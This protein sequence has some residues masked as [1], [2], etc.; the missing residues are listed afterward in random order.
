MLSYEDALSYALS[1]DAVFILGS[2]F[3]VGASSKVDKSLFTGRKLSQELAKEL[4]IKEELELDIIAQEYIDEK[5][6]F[7]LT[8]YLKQH[9]IVDSYLEYYNAFS[10]IKHARIYSTNY[11]NLV[12]RIFSDDRQ[13]INSHTL[14]TEMRKANKNKFILHIT[15]YINNLDNYF[16]DSFR[17]TYRSYDKLLYTPWVKLL[18][19]DIRASNAVFII[20]LSFKSDLDLRRII[21]NDDEIKG[22]CFIIDR[23]DIGDY[24]FKLLSSYG[25]V[26]KNGVSHFCEELSKATPIKYEQNIDRY[27]F[28]SFCKINKTKT[29]ETPTDS[30]VFD[31]FFLG[32]THTHLFHKDL[33]DQFTTLVN[34][35]KLQYAIDKLNNG[36][37]L[38]IH[39]DLG[40][41][42]SIFLDELSYQLEKKDIYLYKGITDKKYTKEVEKLCSDSTPKIIAFDTYNSYLPQIKE[43]ENYNREFVQFIFLAR[44]AMNENNEERLYEYFSYGENNVRIYE[45]DLN[46]MDDEELSQLDTILFRHGLWG[47]YSGES[48]EQRL[49]RLSRNY[50]GQFQNTILD[51]FKD[52]ELKHRFESLIEEEPD[53]KTKKV[54]V[55][56]FINQILELH[57]TMDDFTIF[58]ENINRILRRPIFK[59]FVSITDNSPSIKSSIIAK[60]MILSKTITPELVF[61]ITRN[62][63]ERLDTLYAGN[64]KYIDA[65]KN[66][67]SCSYLSFLFD[68][69][70]DDK[71]ILNYY[72]AVKILN[73][74]KRKP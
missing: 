11:D 54:L 70:L 65:M 43:F 64:E 68:Y 24:D 48:D 63:A 8:K 19:D 66:L 55:L 21:A 41:G 5:G 10:K 34:R 40:N 73:F 67:V 31:L 47:E 39:S 1:G 46:R 74:N 60:A 69:E 25:R 57:F 30:Q 3:S 23:P 18:I 15:G 61:E 49:H 50:K 26:L 71:L 29:Y 32:E 52:S 38:I 6:E 33:K 45:I 12:E 7:E 37:S 59:E 28:K 9:F 13:E 72:E 44:S 27:N 58:F 2:G 35:S 62:V 17:L 36:N 51:L 20:G 42:K 14:L 16:D 4:G 53:E 56:L 22:K